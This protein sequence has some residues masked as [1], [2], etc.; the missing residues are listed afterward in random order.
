[1]EREKVGK[2]V[3]VHAFFMHYLVLLS[4]YF[5]VKYISQMHSETV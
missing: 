1:M 2:F 4:Y 5:R 3:P